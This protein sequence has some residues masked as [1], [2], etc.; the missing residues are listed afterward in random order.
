MT[1]RDYNAWLAV[2]II[3]EAVTRT[4]NAEAEALHDY[5]LSDA[6]EI[7]AFKG[8]GLQLPF[9]GTSSCASRSCW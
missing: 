8:E 2:R 3:G 9:A 1:E 4:G 5:V 6:F 7:A